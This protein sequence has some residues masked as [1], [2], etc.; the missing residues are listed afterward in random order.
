MA[1]KKK[2]K[3]FSILLVLFIILVLGGV[4][5][6]YFSTKNIKRIDI[7]KSD[8]EL[9]IK[10]S[11]TNKDIIN[12]ALFGVDRRSQ[13][14]RGRSDS[15][16]IAS[17]N[18]KNNTIKLTS[19]MRDTAVAIEGHGKEKITHAYAYG[20]PVL[21]IKTLN[22]NF[23]LNIR[24][25]VTVDFFR[26]HEIVDAAGGVLIDVQPDEVKYINAYLKEL[27]HL[28]DR[29]TTKDYISQAGPQT[30]NG[31]QAVSYSRIRYTSG[32]D[33]ERANRQRRVLVGVLNKIKQENPTKALQIVTK[34][35]GFVET[36]LDN[37]KILS[38][39]KDAVNYNPDSIQQYRVP[40]DGTFTTG[41]V[42][43]MWVIKAD[44][45]KNTQ[46]LHEFINK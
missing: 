35:L 13:N 44:L 33:Y 6:F 11:T 18:Q 22:E 15:I 12:I 30:L 37:G 41:T 5:A 23:D 1:R 10:N 29:A 39:A 31:R 40:V 4:G 8:K 42:D 45:E 26:L 3:P 7:P 36:S 14:E 32:G 2:K 28:E 21:A 20:G 9:G 27:N 43:K 16:M 24:D 46:L 25:Y 19:V 17:I 34:M 38:L